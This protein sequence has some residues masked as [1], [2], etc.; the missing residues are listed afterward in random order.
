MPDERRESYKNAGILPI[1]IEKIISNKPLSDYLEKFQDINLVIA[2]NLLLGDI[3]AYLNKNNK[4]IN[5]TKLTDDKFKELVNQLDSGKITNKIFKEILTD[6]METDTSI[7]EILEKKGLNLSND[8]ELVDEII[9]KVL[10]ENEQM[11]NDYKNGN[12]RVIKALM[13]LVMKEAKGKINPSI[14]NT[15]LKE[16]LDA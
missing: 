11:V 6:L 14:A 12:E 1:N 4:T 8:E 3:E 16:K 10:V 15:K 7:D 5:E 9:N 2:S 13:G